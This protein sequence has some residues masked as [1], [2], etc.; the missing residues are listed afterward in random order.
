M[1]RAKEHRGEVMRIDYNTRDYTEGTGAAR[2]NTAYAY[3]PYGYKERCS[4]LLQYPLL[5]AIGC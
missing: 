5:R 4:H 1:M 3:L 2:T